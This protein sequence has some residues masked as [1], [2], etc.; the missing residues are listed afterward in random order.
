[1]GDL[2]LSF[3]KSIA[4]FLGIFNPS[5]QWDPRCDSEFDVDVVV[6]VVF[7][8]CLLLVLFPL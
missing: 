3:G 2:S 5:P 6:V 1:M 7:I 8:V 4:I